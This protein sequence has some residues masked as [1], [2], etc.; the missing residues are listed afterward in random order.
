MEIYDGD[1]L[2]KD[3]HRDA[4]KELEVLKEEFKK[5]EQ[6]KE[7]EKERK[8]KSIED[9]IT[10]IVVGLLGAFFLFLGAL[11]SDYFRGGGQ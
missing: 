4:H 3:P 10:K 2:L 1:K 8:K 6:A 11:L 5:A 9:A 7:D